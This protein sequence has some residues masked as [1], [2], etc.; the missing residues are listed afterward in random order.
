MRIR[1]LFVL[2]V[3]ALVVSAGGASASQSDQPQKLPIRELFDK[4]LAA[5]GNEYIKLRSELIE[6]KNALSFLKA[7]MS[8]KDW[9]TAIL[10][11]AMLDR[12]KDTQRYASYEK[13]LFHLVGKV[14]K[15]H[16]SPIRDIEAVATWS[17]EWR[18]ETLKDYGGP[19]HI[20]VVFDH[21][22]K[23]DVLPFLVELA[24]KDSVAYLDYTKPAFAVEFLEKYFSEDFGIGEGELYY[25]FIASGCNHLKGIVGIE[26]LSPEQRRQLCE[27]VR[28]MEKDMEARAFFRYYATIRLGS[29]THPVAQ[30]ALIELLRLDDNSRIRRY[31]A[32]RIREPN[33][34]AHLRVALQD[35]DPAVRETAALALGR[36]ADAQ[37]VDTLIAMLKDKNLVVRKG[38]AIA[39]GQIGDP[40][41]VEPLAEALKDTDW[42]ARLAAAISLGEIDLDILVNFLRD[43]NTKVRRSVARALGKI[44][45]S[46]A[47]GHLAATLHDKDML[48]RDF[49]AEALGKIGDPRAVVPLI[50]AIRRDAHPDV[51]SSAAKALGEIGA[52]EA[53]EPLIVALRDKNHRVRRNVVRALGKIG[54]SRALEPLEKAAAHDKNI[55]VGR[56]ARLAIREIKK[57]NQSKKPEN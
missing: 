49:A 13:F 17:P 57:K 33:A 21:M 37:S 10:A 25:E 44:K 52:L 53:V 9:K 27:L 11:E 46:R 5:K 16:V 41:A 50:N 7:R 14:G 43:E 24:L 6:R 42:H 2:A 55:D 30:A 36:L 48:V 22:A 26:G 32:E 4:A 19:P 3:V 1:I 39:L 12:I 31:A 34:A 38:A 56:N 54:D 45:D 35:G 8:D 40:N 20:N 15:T 23:E 29:F 18:E 28:I 51:R 47:V